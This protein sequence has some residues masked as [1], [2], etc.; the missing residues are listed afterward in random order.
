[1]QIKNNT[2]KALIKFQFISSLIQSTCSIDKKITHPKVFLKR[3]VWRFLSVFLKYSNQLS[4]T[5]S[6][7]SS[8]TFFVFILKFKFCITRSERYFF[9][10]QVLAGQERTPSETPQVHFWDGIQGIFSGTCTRDGGRDGYL[11]QSSN[12]KAIQKKLIPLLRMKS[13]IIK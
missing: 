6:N 7:E 4:S 12:D 3:L 13:W 10:G 5:E 1:M 2:K 11:C 8:W 9:A